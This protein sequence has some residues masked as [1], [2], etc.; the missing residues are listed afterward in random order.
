MCSE[1]VSVRLVEALLPNR[2][3]LKTAHHRVEEDLQEVHVIPV[4]LLH[5]LNPL[6]GDGVVHAIVL[7]SVLRE[8]RHLLE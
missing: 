6:D 3:K 4:G 1:V 8:L 2:L 5:D 7:G